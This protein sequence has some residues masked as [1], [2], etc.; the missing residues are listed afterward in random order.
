[1]FAYQ[2]SRSRAERVW[3]A[4]PVWDSPNHVLRVSPQ[5]GTAVQTGSRWIR[6]AVK[7][8][9]ETII[10]LRLIGEPRSWPPLYRRRGKLSK[11]APLRSWEYYTGI[12]SRGGHRSNRVFSHPDLRPGLG[13]VSG[14]GMKYMYPFIANI[15]SD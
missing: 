3:T 10:L 5:N 8:N 7:R 6:L 2:R 14:Y 13:G 15:L 11:N 4:V 12:H 1:M 9:R